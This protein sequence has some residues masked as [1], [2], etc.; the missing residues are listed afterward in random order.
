MQA[1]P[2]LCQQCH[3]GQ[4]GMGHQL[5]AD[6]TLATDMQGLVAPLANIT[7]GSRRTMGRSCQNCHTQVH[8]SNH[9]SGARLQR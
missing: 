7:A 2:I 5:F 4:A 3:S 9:P 1:R 8:G 6:N